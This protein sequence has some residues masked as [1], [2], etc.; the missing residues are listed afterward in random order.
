MTLRELHGG[1]LGGW[2]PSLGTR[3][4]E[5][6]SPSVAASARSS[7]AACPARSLM[8]ERFRGCCPFGAPR[9]AARGLSRAVSSAHPSLPEQAPPPAATHAPSTCAE[10]SGWE[11][12]G[13]YRTSLNR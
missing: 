2:G 9:L 3:F 12:S 13:A 4:G 6:E 10:F 5:P 11:M 7:R 8:P 1:L